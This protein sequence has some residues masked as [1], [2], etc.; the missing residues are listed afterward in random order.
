MQFSPLGRSGLSVSRICLGTM[1][2]GLQNTQAEAAEQINHA[3]D[4]GINF[5]DTY[6]IDGSRLDI[7]TR[8]YEIF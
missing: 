4:A 6:A 2:W 8:S 1:T 5:M 7:G 3:L